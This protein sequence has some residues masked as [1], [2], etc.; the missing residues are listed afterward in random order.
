M[1]DVK[2]EGPNSIRAFV[3]SE[4]GKVSVSHDPLC[5]HEKAN[6]RDKQF[7]ITYINNMA[8][9]D[10]VFD[11][12]IDGERIF[13]GYVRPGQLYQIFGIQ[14]SITSVLPFKFQE[15]ELVGAFPGHPWQQHVYS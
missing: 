1:H 5:G 2:Q 7:R 15:L 13:R 3:A 14:K 9:T 12:Y 10:L 4:A 11:L 6:G 8:N